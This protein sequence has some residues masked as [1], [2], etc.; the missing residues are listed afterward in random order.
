MQCVI[1]SVNRVSLF[2]FRAFHNSYRNKYH[3][4]YEV[5]GNISQDETHDDAILQSTVFKNGSAG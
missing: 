4:Q 2:K 3:D 1:Y 5:S